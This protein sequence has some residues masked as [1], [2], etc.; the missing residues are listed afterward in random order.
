MRIALREKLLLTILLAMAVAATAQTVL[1]FEVASVKPVKT[2][3]D[4]GGMEI[5]PGGGLRMGGATLES[6]IALAY[7]VRPEQVSGG[8]PWVRT[9]GYNVLAKPEQ[10]DSAAGPHTAPGTPAWG[11]LRQRLQTLLAD[12]FHLT[13]HEQTKPAAG[14]IL[15]IAKE[16][17]KVK[18]VDEADHTPAGTMRSHGAID[19]R[20][21]TM[22]MLA[23]VLTGMLQRPVEDRTGLTGRYTYKLEYRQEDPGGGD[24]TASTRPSVFAALQEQMGLKLESARTAVKTIVIDRAERPS[25]N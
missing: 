22:A 3:G 4:R 20:A 13:V 23:T 5:L 6:L 25:E 19:G 16:G 10:A 11:R 24:S 9:A 14:Y 1:R 8:P 17:F 18:P 21:G 7:D 12:R 15:V 2:E